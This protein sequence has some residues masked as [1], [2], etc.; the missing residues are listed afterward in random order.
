MRQ[1]AGGGQEMHACRLEKDFPFI[2]FL[3]EER[4]QTRG[5]QSL[6]LVVRL[7]VVLVGAAST[8]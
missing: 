5:G 8:A 4:E 2:L 7:V 6:L 3:H 1:A